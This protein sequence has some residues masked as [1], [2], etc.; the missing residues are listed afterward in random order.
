MDLS[1]PAANQKG[2]PSTT[3]P[4]ETVLGN[5]QKIWYPLSCMT[6]TE[7]CWNKNVT[8]ANV[9]GR[10]IFLLKNDSSLSW[11]LSGFHSFG[12]HFYWWWHFTHQ[13]K[14]ETWEHDGMTTA[15]SNGTRNTN[16]QK[17][18]NHA[19]RLVR[20]F[21]LL[22]LEIKA[23]RHTWNVGNNPSLHRK[24]VYKDTG[25]VKLYW[26]IHTEVYMYCSLPSHR[27]I[28]Q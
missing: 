4:S 15:K 9:Q 27:S 28:C 8:S 20:L 2:L 22:Y 16:G 25:A 17:D 3:V 6:F 21:Y 5:T 10:T 18:H 13:S 7:F 19:T 23:S 12:P 11:H 24:P 1:G 26:I 14:W